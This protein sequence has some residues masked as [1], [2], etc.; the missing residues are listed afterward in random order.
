MCF[1]EA[2]L[3]VLLG[4]SP[5]T[6]PISPARPRSPPRLLGLHLPLCFSLPAFFLPSLFLSYHPHRSC[7]LASIFPA[8][9]QLSVF[10]FCFFCFTCAT[11]GAV[12]SCTQTDGIAS[13]CRDHS[14]VMTGTPDV[15]SKTWISHFENC[16]CSVSRSGPGCSVDATQSLARFAFPLSSCTR[17]FTQADFFLQSGQISVSCSLGGCKMRCNL[18]SAVSHRGEKQTRILTDTAVSLKPSQ[19]TA[20]ADALLTFHLRV[21]P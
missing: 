9:S 3:S 12:N 1:T 10:G 8:R 2:I 5:F 13:G 4:S 15:L 16:S 17:A 20:Q 19:A 21:L 11:L 14:A 18:T 6:H 7:H